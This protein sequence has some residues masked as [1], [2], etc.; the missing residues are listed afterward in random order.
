MRA[1]TW[2]ALIGL[3]ILT[4]AAQAADAYPTPPVPI[5]AGFVPGATIDVTARV[6]APKLGAAFN[7]QFVVENKTGA[8]SNLAAD[9]VAHAAKDRHT[10]LV[11]TI[12][13][14][15]NAAMGQ[16]RNFD[17]EKDFAPIA[18]VATVPNI[19]VVH[20]SI[21]VK[22]V[23]DLIKL[24]RA[25]PDELSYGSSGAGSALHL[26]AELFKVMT[27]T[28]M[29]HVPYA[30][31]NQAVADLLTGRVQVMFSPAST[32]L[33]HVQEGKLIALAST[34]LKRASVAPD[35]PTM[36]EAGLK[37]FDTSVWSGLMAPADTPRDIVQKLARATNEALKSR[38]VIEPLQKQ[39]ID[40]LGGTP[41]EFADYIRSETAKW[42][43]VVAAAGMKQ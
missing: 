8:G 36:E 27:G 37:G 32:V 3:A 14:T 13:N 17:F 9:F 31:S 21:G 28:K 7:Q 2:I 19:L 23:D 43:R 33:Q 34:Q 38:D 5:V 11:G 4:L 12:A 20:P 29:V 26:S 30:G 24:A 16:K 40:M 15:I 6:L 22:S 1:L 18:L 10:L 25:K 41:Q 39:G 35:L 42:T